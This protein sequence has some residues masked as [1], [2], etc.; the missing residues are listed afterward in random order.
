MLLRQPSA[1]RGRNI[2]TRCHSLSRPFVF[3]VFP[4]ALCGDGKNG[5]STVVS[6]LKLL[7]VGT[8]K[9]DDRY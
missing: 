3:C 4:G 8:N 1:S 2:V 7:R 6:R 5:N 9:S